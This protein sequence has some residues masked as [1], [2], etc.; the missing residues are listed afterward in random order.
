LPSAFKNPQGEAEYMAAYD[1]S[2]NRLVIDLSPRARQVSFWAAVI[3]TASNG[4][5]LAAVAWYM[6]AGFS[7]P[8]PTMTRILASVSVFLFA[9]A[10]VVLV[11]ILASGSTLLYPIYFS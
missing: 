3:A 2:S 9:P 7:P 8:Q 10:M 11:A 4:L 5:Y 1:A 6:P